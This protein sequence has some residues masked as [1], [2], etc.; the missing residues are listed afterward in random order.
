MFIRANAFHHRQFR[1]ILRSSET[2]AED[3]L[4]HSTV[5]WL[6]IGETSRRVLQLRKEIVEYYSTKNKKCPLLDTDFFM[7]LGFLV[8]F[9]TQINFL[10]QSLQ[11]KATTVC[12]VY[13][14]VQDFRGKCRLLKSYLHQRNF[15][16][17]PQM[18][19]L[20]DSKEIQ[21]DDISI[22]LFS[23]VFDGVLQVF[24][25]RFK[26][27]ERVS[28]TT[29]LVAY[30]HLVETETAPL[31][32]QMELVEL[33]N[34]EQFVKKS[35]DEEDLLDSWRGAVKYSILQELARKTLVLFGS[36]C[37]CEA[38]FSRIKYVKNK[39]RTRLSDSNR[40]CELRLM[41]SSEPPN[42]ASFSEEVQD[43]ASH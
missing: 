3:I 17:F 25:N 18:K 20:I 12:F 38:G 33:K 9:L 15:F 10:N 40:E 6:S 35:K 41:I 36:T 4:Y 29:R 8:D 34:D 1:E 22:I 21:V 11:G 5:C 14:K 43:Q 2:S 32:L 24:S 39:H 28:D 19:V 26:D 31:N 42:F 13:K 7:S 16:H 23:S 27:F 30:L 37:V